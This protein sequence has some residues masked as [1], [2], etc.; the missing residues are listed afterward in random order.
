MLRWTGQLERW[1][2][3]QRARRYPLALLAVTVAL[4]AWQALR[5]KDYVEPGGDLVGRDFLAFYMAG[6]L[7]AEGDYAGLY[8]L[9][10]Q[11]EY[12]LEFMRQRNPRWAK[13]C[14]YFNP[15]HYALAMSWLA[16]LGYGGAFLAWSAASVVFFLANVAI[17]ACW[18]DV[19]SLRPVALL[20]VCFPPWFLAL[21]GGQNTFLSLLL[22]TAFCA[23]L[24]RGRPLSAGIVL[25]LLSYKFQFLV[26]PALW[27]VLTRQW[28][29]LTGVLLG[30]G[31]TLV[32]TVWACGLD[33]VSAYA[34]FLTG[35]GEVMTREGFDAHKQHSWYG[36]WYILGQ[37]WLP[38]TS[39]Q[40][41]AF[42]SSLATLVV[43]F[44]MPAIDGTRASVSPQSLCAM[45][46]AQIATCPHLFHYDVLLCVLPAA[47]WITGRTAR[48][49]SSAIAAPGTSARLTRAG[50]VQANYAN[51][52]S[53]LTSPTALRRNPA[54]AD[55]QMASGLTLLIA[56]LFAW[57]ACAAPAALHLRI[58][59]SPVILTAALWM[60]RGRKAATAAS[61]TLAPPGVQTQPA[62]RGSCPSP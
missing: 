46:L 5:A 47:L 7:A 3:P 8:R 52:G 40:I 20:S 58:Q 10:R 1:I 33:A 22:M 41:L 4:Y 23:L 56:S 44:A 45:T 36:F 14:I 30:G 59:L 39:I 25:S 34:G 48:V 62:A 6:E 9:Q 50:R 32:L 42:T 2:T 16:P 49:P 61:A 15:P 60:V 27:L 55:P 12:Q 18:L 11:S 31:A 29:A 54:A 35:L 26:V 51:N 28:R 17:F 13:T 21:A 24:M 43:A 19:A 38:L 57:M 53:G 37:E